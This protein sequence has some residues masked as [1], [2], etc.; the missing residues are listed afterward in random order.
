MN[1]DAF[2]NLRQFNQLIKKKTCNDCT[3]K[4]ISSTQMLIIEYLLTHGDVTQREIEGFLKTSRATVSDVIKTMEKNGI[5]LKKACEID[6]RKNIITLTDCSKNE[7]NKFK[8]KF[9]EMQKSA[10]KDVTEEELSCFNKVLKKMIDNLEG[11]EINE[12]N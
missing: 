7:I 11:D 2:F 3:L 9:I 4:K 1:N 8:E 5:I 6:S 12:H 10:V